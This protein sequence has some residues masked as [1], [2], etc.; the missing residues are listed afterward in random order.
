MPLLPPP[1][2]APPTGFFIEL[3]VFN[4]LAFGNCFFWV[5]FCSV[6]SFQAFLC[7][8]YD[9][10]RWNRLPMDKS[11]R[12]LHSTISRLSIALTSKIRHA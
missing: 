1:A 11:T 5:D 2:L 12:T 4:S 9:W 3:V 6:V 10:N 8:L 7:F